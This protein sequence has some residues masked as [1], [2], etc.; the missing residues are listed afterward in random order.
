[1]SDEQYRPTEPEEEAPPI[2]ATPPLEPGARP[3]GVR[4]VVGVIVALVVLAAIVA[5]AIYALPMLL[6]PD[7]RE[8]LAESVARYTSAQYVQ[9]EGTMSLEMEMGGQSTSSD[10]KLE[11]AWAAPNKV[12][13]SAHIGVLGST[14]VCDGTNLYMS[15]DMLD[16]VLKVP[17]PAT[18]AEMPTE[19]M[20][21]SL[22]G[23]M[24]AMKIPDARSLIAGDFDP[25]KL[26]D[27]RD[28][29]DREDEWLGSLD[30]PRGTW[31][32]TVTIAEGL[33]VVMWI[34]R[35][36]HLVKQSAMACD[37][38]SMMSAMEQADPESE[39][40]QELQ[41]AQEMVR[42][43][44][45]DMTMRIVL[46]EDRTVIGEA[47]PE[48][49][50]DFTP[51]EG[52]TVIEGDDFEEAMARLMAESMPEMPHLPPSAGAPGEHSGAGDR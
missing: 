23:G 48:G 26:K 19:G 41:Q 9:S 38:E 20:G 43:M 1:V 8:L 2:A 51:P 25:E 10:V 13:Y 29:L 4:R 34:D 3:R 31:P 32:I 24:P 27:V 5:I 7:A 50:F 17:A 14:T 42:S 35:A 18:L 46:S 16:A 28:G 39:E 30:E 33:D 49:T 52:A 36:T 21:G 37:F 6:R 11:F 12:L 40:L 45:G 22:G 44:F 47:P 15:I